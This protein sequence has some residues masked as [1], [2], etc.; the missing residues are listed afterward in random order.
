M[1]HPLRGTSH[2]GETATPGHMWVATSIP[3]TD[4]RIDVEVKL[5]V[6]MEGLCENG[7]T[8]LDA[9]TGAVMARKVHDAVVLADKRANT[10]A[11][12]RAAVHKSAI[13]DAPQR[14]RRQRLQ[15]L[16]AVKAHESGARSRD[17]RGSGEKHASV[18]CAKLAGNRPS[19]EQGGEQKAHQERGPNE[20]VARDKPTPRP[21][22]WWGLQL[23][24]PLGGQAHERQEP[25]G[26]KQ[27]VFLSDEGITGDL[28]ARPLDERCMHAL[29]Q[30][31]PRRDLDRL[32]TLV[33]DCR[34]TLVVEPVRL[35]WRLVGNFN[36]IDWIRFPKNTCIDWTR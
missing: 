33:S 22:R 2:H 31:A 15:L 17:I 10:D 11:V 36:C 18:L 9:D 34:D 23:L 12:E 3:A 27:G 5:L 7:T 25:L 19:H 16:E 24:E 26:A 20:A 8:S 6:A 28:S 1:L 35:G 29:L 21:S 13:T 14:R 30:L 4:R 32:C